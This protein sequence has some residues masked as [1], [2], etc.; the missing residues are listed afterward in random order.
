MT[1]GT[2]LDWGVPQTVARIGRIIWALL[3]LATIAL[4]L[5]M[6]RGTFIGVPHWDSWGILTVSEIMGGFFKSISGHVSSVPR[7]IYA[8]DVLLVSG[9]SALS[10]A[11][12]LVLIAAEA[13]MLIWICRK[14]G[15]GF[16]YQGLVVIV[17]F[18]AY[19]IAIFMSPFNLQIVAVFV[20]ATASFAALAFGREKGVCIAILFATING[21]TMA[22]GILTGLVLVPLALILGLSRRSVLILALAG[23]GIVLAYAFFATQSE[24]RLCVGFY[25]TAPVDNY[26]TLQGIGSMLAYLGVYL[27]APIA[28]LLFRST[29]F[30]DEI[31]LVTG[32]IGYVGMLVGAGLAVRALL[33]AEQRQ[34]SVIGFLLASLAYLVG[35]AAVTSYARGVECPLFSAGTSRYG[36]CADHFWLILILLA[37]AQPLSRKPWAT[38]L[39]ALGAAAFGLVLAA[40]QPFIVKTMIVSPDLSPISTGKPGE[41]FIGGGHQADRIAARTAMLSSTLDVAALSLVMIGPDAKAI[42]TFDSM[43]EQRLAPFQHPWSGLLGQ[44]LPDDYRRNDRSCSGTVDAPVALPD[45]GWRIS[46]QLRGSDQQFDHIIVVN[47]AGRVAGYAM[48]SPGRTFGEALADSNPGWQGHINGKL[49]VGSLILLALEPDSKTACRFGQVEARRL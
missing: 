32:L 7:L 12:T 26:F 8:A 40:S 3:G 10:L 1:I 34:R 45:G 44:P 46:G 27:G 43:R 9:S 6:I 13:L 38:T 19:P 18:W 31:L 14:A 42:A 24:D 25:N 41:Q 35:T 11:V 37:A 39:P 5:V 28:R 17:L 47:A 2:K 4:L 23:I 30:T 49:G 22:N 48:R 36:V 29:S 15:L 16:V 20:F 33:L 21:F